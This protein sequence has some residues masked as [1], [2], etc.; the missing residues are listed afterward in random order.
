MPVNKAKT[1]GSTFKVRSFGSFIGT[2]VVEKINEAPQTA[3]QPKVV[4]PGENEANVSR[5]A[6]KMQLK[7]TN[8]VEVMV[9]SLLERSISPFLWYQGTSL[10]SS[11]T[12]ISPFPF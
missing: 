7:T 4:P 9:I 2:V 1:I 6:A 11:K 10:A 8:K 3:I 12:P 5:T